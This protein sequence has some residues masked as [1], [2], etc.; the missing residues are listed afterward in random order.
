[1]TLYLA[2]VA[3]AAFV[4]SVLLLRAGDEESEDRAVSG[5]HSGNRFGPV[6]G[7]QPAELA[8]RIFSQKDREFILLMR[9]SRLQRLYLEE[10][11]KVALHWVRRISREVSQIM[12]NHRLRSRQSSNLNVT[13]EMK[14]FFLY[15]ELRFLC[16]MLLLLIQLFGPHALLNLAARTGELYQQIGRALSEVGAVNRTA[17]PGN[18]A[19]S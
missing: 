9:S 1:M 7:L 12:R 18:I 3:A 10:R 16:G 11:R 2:L 4:I 6:N 5:T 8:S 13:V 15:L 17:S 14:L 19:A